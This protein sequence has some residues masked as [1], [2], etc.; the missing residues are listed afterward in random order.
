MAIIED[1]YE[2]LLDEEAMEALP[3]RL[4]A[5]VGARSS[6]FQIHEGGT[7]THL[8]TSYF[9]PEMSRY[10]AEEGVYAF[11]CWT[12]TV[13]EREMFDRA[14]DS[15]LLISREQF[16]ETPFYNEF[17]R[18][19]GDD[20]GHSIGAVLRTRTGIVGLGLQHAF[21]SKTFDD[22]AIETLENALPHLKR[23]AEA[24]AVVS[25]ADGRVRD[26]EAL[27]DAQAT[28]ILLVDRLGVIRFANAASER[29]LARNDGLGSRGGMLRATGADAPVL[30]A[31]IGRA[32]APRPEGDALVIARPSGERGYRLLLA[33]HRGRGA[34]PGRVMVM[35][36]DPA[37]TDT[38]LADRLRALFDLSAAEADLAARLF[39]GESMAEASDGR[40]VLISTS[41]S[42]LNAILAKTGLHRQGEL[43]AMIGHLPR[44]MS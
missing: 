43:M 30:E 36:D 7:I 28:A 12:N 9:S 2:A 15:D 24:R 19:F 37:Q 22:G 34:R 41:R 32:A 5:A 33:P 21:G 44:P 23:M 27:L 20:T 35:I 25:R 11:D 17:F 26:A 10:Y 31:A 38:G 14:V 16:R 29:I 6:S 1:I 3:G 4:A 13:I 42:Q 39:V 40:G 8:G 18:R